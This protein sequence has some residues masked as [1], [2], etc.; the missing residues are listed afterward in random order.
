MI[1]PGPNG[2]PLDESAIPYWQSAQ[3]GFDY[4]RFRQ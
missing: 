3:F 1:I 2:F 4:G